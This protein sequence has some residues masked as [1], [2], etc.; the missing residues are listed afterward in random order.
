MKISCPF[1]K[2]DRHPSCSVSLATGVWIC[3]AGCGSGDWMDFVERIRRDPD[4]APLASE[5]IKADRKPVL[6][7]LLE[8][9]LTRDMLSRWDIEWDSKVGAMQLPLYDHF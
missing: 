2:P 4:Y 3:F 1:H 7:S 8:R 6:K 5:D 9:G